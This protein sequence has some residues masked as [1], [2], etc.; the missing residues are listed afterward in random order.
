M[1]RIRTKKGRQEAIRRLTTVMQEEYSNEITN[2]LNDATVNS[3][4]PLPAPDARDYYEG[5]VDPE[6]TIVSSSGG[7]V[8]VYWTNEGPRS[9]ATT[10]SA[11][12]N[13]GEEHRT[14]KLAGNILFRV[15]Q[16]DKSQLRF[17]DQNG[18]DLRP[19]TPDEVMRLRA[20][21]YVGAMDEAVRK[22][23][24]DGQAIHD[25]EMTDDTAGLMPVDEDFGPIGIAAAM[26]EVTQRT[27]RPRMQSLP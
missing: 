24:A 14:L 9:L 2:L 1:S 11:G 19:Y 15:E 27:E 6:D 26:F 18:N 8:A 21:R 25:I 10:G 4:L 17:Q 3:A 5:F 16:Y 13:G 7:G 20:E 22:Y 12:P 23:G